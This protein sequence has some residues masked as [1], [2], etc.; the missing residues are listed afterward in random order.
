MTGGC[1]AVKTITVT[2]P[3]PGGNIA[4]NGA[5]VMELYPNPTTGIINVNVNVAGTLVIYS[6]EGKQMAQYQIQSGVTS[7]NIPLNVA[8]GMYIC[9]FNGDDGSSAM[10]RLIYDVR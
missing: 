10:V 4:A 2:T 3:R 5:A 9:R 1:F 8:A 6:L 7:M